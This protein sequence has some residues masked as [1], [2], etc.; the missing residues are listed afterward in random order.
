MEVEV[1]AVDVG[2]NV[3]GATSGVWGVGGP[4]ADEGA[5][6]GTGAIAT[7]DS[8]AALSCSMAQRSDCIGLPEFVIKILLRVNYTGYF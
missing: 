5:G 8:D 2:C 3:G 6:K 1:E 4:G 7:D